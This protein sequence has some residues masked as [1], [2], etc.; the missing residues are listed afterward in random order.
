MEC[1]QCK[2]PLSVENAFVC[3]WCGNQLPIP[4]ESFFTKFE[5]LYSNFIDKLITNKKRLFIIFSI[6]LIILLFLI[7]RN[8]WK[9]WFTDKEPIKN[10]ITESIDNVIVPKGLKQTRAFEYLTKVRKELLKNPDNFENI[11]IKYSQDSLLSSCKGIAVDNGGGVLDPEFDEMALKLEIN[12]VSEI[13]EIKDST[14]ETIKYVIMKLLNKGNGYYEAQYITRNIKLEIGQ[15]YQGGI[16]FHLD[17]NDQHG[18]IAAK[19]DFCE[20]N[21]DV[22]IRKCEELELNG[23]DDWQLPS[24]DELNLLYNSK[25]QI[26]GFAQKWYWSSTYATKYDAWRQYFFGGG[27]VAD[28][29][30]L[31]ECIMVRAIRAF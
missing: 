29:S 30:L 15:Y 8:N 16:I 13:F 4:E 7:L 11:A 22:A 14:G 1:P 31:Y 19:N 23:H 6:I 17:D 12:K 25:D 21:T 9:H 5:R 20:S 10:E 27:Q 18:L 28:G 3:E 26:G 2:N 24:K